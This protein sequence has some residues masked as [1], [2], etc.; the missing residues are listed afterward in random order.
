MEKLLAT[1]TECF[2]IL[3]SS[4]I[5]EFTKLSMIH[6]SYTVRC[7]DVAYNKESIALLQA[8]EVL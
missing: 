7:S 4:L 5:N 1:N 3:K 6:F 8:V 2:Q